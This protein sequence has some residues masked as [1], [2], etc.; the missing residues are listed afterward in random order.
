[1]VC[2][3]F[4]LKLKNKNKDDS[5]EISIMTNYNVS[6]ISNTERKWLKW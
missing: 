1:M 6:N 5:H 4:F 3:V 2:M